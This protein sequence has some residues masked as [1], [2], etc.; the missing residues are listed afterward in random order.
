MTNTEEIMTELSEKLGNIGLV[1]VV[2]F[3]KLEYA[4]PTAK[5][6]IDGGLPV[7]EITLRTEPAIEAMKLIKKNYP[8][9]IMGAGTVL[10]VDQAKL[11]LMQAVS[12]L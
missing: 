9:I 5:A 3:D 8:E 7:M 2:V 6:L 10:S 11:L 1:P 4:L 12:S